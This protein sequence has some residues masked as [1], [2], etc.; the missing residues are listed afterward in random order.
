MPFGLIEN[1]LHI[2]KAF[3]GMVDKHR[4]TVERG[5]AEGFLKAYRLTF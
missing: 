3:N 5:I 4:Q 1:C 2:E